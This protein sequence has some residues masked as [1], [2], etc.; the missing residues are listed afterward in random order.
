MSARAL[1]RLPAPTL[2]REGSWTIGSVQVTPLY[3]GTLVTPPELIYSLASNHYPVVPGSRGLEPDHWS[4]HDDAL[5]EGHL[6]LTFGGF[7]VEPGDGRVV[8]VD[9]GQGPTDWAPEPEIAPQTYGRLLDSLRAVG[10]EPEDVT[11]VVITHLHS[12]HVGWAATD[13]RPTFANATYRCHA[14]DL[15][16]FVPSNEIATRALTPVLDRLVV[17]SGA[18]TIGGPIAVRPA[19]GHTPGT[20]IV[21]IE[22]DGGQF[23]LLGD[24]YHSVPELV[25]AIRWCGMADG[26]A[27]GAL[28]T[29]L[30][31]ADRLEHGEIPFAA[32]HFPGMPAQR[33]VRDNGRRVLVDS[34]L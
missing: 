10:R 4:E 9:T 12:D 25:D 31:V 32:A 7:L 19:P 1:D 28:R 24:V 29:R 17:W 15:R 6:E 27:M 23:W 33:L 20:T 3:D 11:D 18:E 2:P 26:D 8:L 30:E 13:G 16:T 5:A 14:D 22:S 34:G 21:T